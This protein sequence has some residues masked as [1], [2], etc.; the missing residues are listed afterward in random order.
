MFRTL[1][2]LSEAAQACVALLHQVGEQ[3]ATF[4]ATP[5]PDLAQKIQDLEVSRATWE[6]EVEAL[7]LKA[8]GQYDS[9]RNAEERQK[10]MKKAMNAEPEDGGVEG[11]EELA[12]A[13]REAG[14]NFSPPHAQGGEGEELLPV[15]TSLAILAKM[16]PINAKWAGR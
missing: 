12:A 3:L 4:Q 5:N 16:A 1:K 15:P 7:I 8:K 10:T 2:D 9:A 14:L 6:A 13:Y 11:M